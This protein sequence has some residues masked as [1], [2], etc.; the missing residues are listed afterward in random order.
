M[1][2]R[3]ASLAMSTSILKALPGQVDIKRHE[4]SILYSFVWNLI[5]CNLL[6]LECFSVLVPSFSV[7]FSFTKSVQKIYNRA[8]IN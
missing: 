8:Y 5:T 7:T 4:P 6:S 1:L 2:T 3:S